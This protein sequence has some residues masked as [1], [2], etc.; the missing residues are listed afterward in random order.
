[1]ELTKY[2][3]LDDPKFYYEKYELKSARAMLSLLYLTLILH[4]EAINHCFR[5]LRYIGLMTFDANVV[6][7]IFNAIPMIESS[8]IR[9][10]KR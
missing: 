3:D 8:E 9:G 5:L 4:L 1:M 6:N 2:E 7:L 10:N